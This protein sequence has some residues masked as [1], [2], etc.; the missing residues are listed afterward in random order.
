[1]DALRDGTGGGEYRLLHI[2]AFMSLFVIGTY[3]GSF[4]PA[5][6]FFAADVGV[7]L[8]TA[9]LVL[10]ALFLGSITASASIAI[11]LHTRD[12]RALT[13]VGLVAV[14]VGL[15]ALGL[16]PNWPLL[17]AGG[18]TIGAG[19]GLMI[20]ALHILI[21]ATSRDVPSAINKLNVFF[22]FGAIAGPVWTGAVLATTGERSIVYAGL[23]AFA[24]LVLAVLVAA[25]APRAEQTVASD[26]FRLPG[27][28]T[29]WIMGAVLFLYVGAEFGLGAWVSSYT[30]ETAHAG[31][32]TSALLASGYWAAL[33]LGRLLTGAYFAGGRDA[34]TLLLISAAGAG[35]ASL[36]LSLSSGQVAVSA[37]AVFFA[38][39]FL[40]PLWPGTVAIASEGSMAKATA[41]TITIGNAGGL[42]IP[43]L[44]GRVLVGAGPAQGVAVTAALC[45]LMFIIVLGFRTGRRR[46]L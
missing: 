28:L 33:A 21:A 34:S 2:A 14:I 44:Q 12:A 40:G 24:A 4:G 43:W 35:I 15:L 20:A 30:R 37:L 41:A 6:P 42:A 45:G 19:D 29:A 26:E 3:A 18:V 17:L 10:T 32:F 9:G 1:M 27:H 38:G 36:V 16:A 39:L 25:P 23:A 11:A 7:S 22:A 31:V 13:I 5:L 8:D 46:L